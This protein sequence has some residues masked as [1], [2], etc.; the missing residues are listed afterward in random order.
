MTL[1]KK[2]LPEMLALLEKWVNINTHSKNRPGIE[3]LVIELQKEFQRV[4][5]EE[6]TIVNF[7]NSSGLFLKKR[8]QAPL[9]IFF[10][11]HL[12][13]VYPPDSPFQ[14]FESITLEKVTGPGVTDMKGGL[15]VLLMALEAFENS[16]HAVSIGWEIFINSDEEIGSPESYPFLEKCAERAH[17][18]C[19]FEPALDDGA[20][21]SQRKGS[22]NYHVTSMGRKAHAGRSAIEGKHAI[23]PLA[24]FIVKAE[25]M[26]DPS[27]GSLVNVGVMRG[28]EAANV[29]PDFAECMV[30]V[31]S[32]Q[33][34]TLLRIEK[35]LE[36][37][38]AQEGLS[39]VKKTFR[40]PKPF[41]ARTQALYEVLKACAQKLG[42]PLSWRSSGGVCDGNFF[43][44]KGV[45]T[46]DSLGVHGGMIHTPHEFLFV[47]S[48]HEK[49]EL[50]FLFLKE[51]G[52][53]RGQ[54]NSG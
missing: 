38:A 19:L 54:L 15:V 45:P 12:D 35:E 29:I 4:R 43:A 21:V 16:K 20:L 30:N 3:L 42:F 48:L 49:A 14:K 26:H 11:G 10:G 46:I 2:K 41:D 6:S 47:E 53:F 22:S 34:K 32:D 51:I 39:I 24:R 25:R 17:L 40:P 37:Q 1:F 33:L 5:P 8:S 18:A 9:Q 44:N 27:Q 13:T 23:Y 7:A 52:E 36:R 31:R 28:G 50:T